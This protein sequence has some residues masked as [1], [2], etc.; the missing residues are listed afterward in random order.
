MKKFRGKKIDDCIIEKIDGKYY[1]VD[2]IPLDYGEHSESYYQWIK[3]N[4]WVLSN[5]KEKGE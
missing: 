3:E 2:Y 1:I 5:L 4:G